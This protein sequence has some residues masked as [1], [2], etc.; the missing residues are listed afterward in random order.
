MMTN[1]QP[2]IRWE[3]PAGTFFWDWLE[4]LGRPVKSV[5]VFAPHADD[6][7]LAM[8]SLM[9][10]FADR[11]VHVSVILVWPGHRCPGLSG[12]S[13]TDHEK[14]QLRELEQAAACLVTR[15]VMV[16]MQLAGGYSAGYDCPSEECDR[17][18]QILAEREPDVL[19]VGPLYDCESH[20]A[21]RTLV[22]RALSDG[23]IRG[24]EIVTW[25][26]TWNPL[27]GN[28]PANLFFPYGPDLGKVKA[29]ALNQF[30]SQMGQIPYAEKAAHHDY[31]TLLR[32]WELAAGHHAVLAPDHW[33]RAKV[34]CECF[35]WEQYDP[36][37]A[38]TDPIHAALGRLH[39]EQS[40]TRTGDNG[41]RREAVV[42]ANGNGD[43]EL[44]GHDGR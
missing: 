25:E 31:D 20:V 16:P 14:A 11:G 33:L 27:G 2:H 4:Q 5:A 44:P 30:A 13:L 29:L 19:F 42:A 18:V 34:G 32:V 43:D 41:T 6:A 22:G 36:A 26:S 37:L 9:R 23:S 12:L 40:R 38:E 8:A 35:R 21:V 24:C 3:L 17:I 7:E 39:W 28:T 10:W 1:H 15:S